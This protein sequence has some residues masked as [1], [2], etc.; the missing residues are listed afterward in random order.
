MS[1][2]I[3]DTDMFVPQKMQDRLNALLAQGDLA[4]IFMGEE[5]KV[6]TKLITSYVLF[7][8]L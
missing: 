8:S 6:E 7:H 5:I 4:H 1:H 2:D 3:N